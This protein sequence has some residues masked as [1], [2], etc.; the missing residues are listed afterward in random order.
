MGSGI[1]RVTIIGEGIKGGLP[2]PHA[3]AQ[4]GGQSQG[5]DGSGS[6]GT[7]SVR[8]AGFFEQQEPHAAGVTSTAALIDISF[9]MSAQ[10]SPAQ[11]NA[12]LG[13]TSITDMM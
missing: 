13:M 8:S 7:G 2:N 4:P 1:A 12:A 10:F 9:L 3:A 5:V 6:W 11:G